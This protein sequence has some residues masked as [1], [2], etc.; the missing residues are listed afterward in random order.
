[1]KQL[2]ILAKQN[3]VSIARTKSDFIKTL[4]QVEPAID[5]SDLTGAAL[6]AKL[7]EHKIGLLRTKEEL[8]E[9]PAEKQ[10]ALLQAQLLQC[11]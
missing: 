1:M 3:G 11:N 6:K 9:L 10:T 4:D 8:V 2:Q 5:H 7:K